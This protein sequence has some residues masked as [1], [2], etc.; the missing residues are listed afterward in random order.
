MCVPS[1]HP[2]TAWPHQLRP[3][4]YSANPFDLSLQTLCARF[5]P[6]SFMYYQSCEPV[7]L[8]KI[9]A[10]LFFKRK[11]PPLRS[12]NSSPFFHY[13]RACI[14]AGKWIAASLGDQA[15]FSVLSY[16]ERE[17]SLLEQVH[18][19]EPKWCECYKTTF[20][21]STLSQNVF[22]AIHLPISIL[23]ATA[24]AFFNLCACG[25]GIHTY[26][27]TRTRRKSSQSSRNT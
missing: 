25:V 10:C 17:F 8:L 7:T 2:P 18:M 11:I 27:N 4:R 15:C 12:E 24:T 16:T 13:M 9:C 26:T 20:K 6:L 23:I 3:R 22:Q 19:R 14:L 5:F 1:S 21:D